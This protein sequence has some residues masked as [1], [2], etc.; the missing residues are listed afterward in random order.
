MSDMS[1]QSAYELMRDAVS[2]GEHEKV[3]GIA[4]H[5]L[6]YFPQNLKAK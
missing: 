4:R 5:I 2:R 1:L 6:Q 3:A